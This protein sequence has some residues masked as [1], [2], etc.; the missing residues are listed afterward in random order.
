MDY[1]ATD[2]WEPCPWKILNGDLTEPHVRRKSE[3]VYCQGIWRLDP[4]SENRVLDPFTFCSSRVT[5][6][7]VLALGECKHLSSFP[8]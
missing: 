6:S 4:S 1:R 8:A 7:L 2:D 5:L 3:D